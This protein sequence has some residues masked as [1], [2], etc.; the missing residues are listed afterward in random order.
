MNTVTPQFLLTVNKIKFNTGPFTQMTITILI[1]ILLISLL[2]R[3]FFGKKA[4]LTHAVSSALGITSVYVLFAI[5][6]GLNGSL[7]FLLDPLPFVSVSGSTLYVFPIFKTSFKLLCSELFS[8]LVLALAMNLIETWLPKGKKF[9]TWILLRMLSVILA[10]VAHYLV[11]LLLVRFLPASFTEI[12]STA[13]IILVLL[14]LLLGSLKILIAGALAF[15]NPLLALLYSFFFVNLIGRQFTRA[16]LT[17]VM[18]SALVWA[19][20]HYGMTAIALGVG[21]LAVY[22]PA[23]AILL[24]IWFI[25]GRLL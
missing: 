15:I 19:M 5:L 3:L 20:N 22:L 12:S 4:T 18:L 13:M 1:A 8:M 9:Y 10:L 16:I 7:G 14:A 11:H 21:S 23:L 6:V 17:T 2:G 24:I 25:A